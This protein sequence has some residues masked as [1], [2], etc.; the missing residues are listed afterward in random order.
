MFL[1]YFAHFLPPFVHQVHLLY[2]YLMADRKFMVFV[3]DAL[4]LVPP[5]R[6][7]G[8]PHIDHLIFRTM[9]EEDFGHLFG[10]RKGFWNEWVGQITAQTDDTFD[11]L[12]LSEHQ[13]LTEHTSLAESKEPDLTGGRGIAFDEFF[14]ELFESIQCFQCLGNIC[15]E[16]LF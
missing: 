4:I 5:M 3:L 9:D 15:F 12:T 14:E 13:C 11:L 7:A 2:A 6:S 8:L 10:R 16:S 1:S